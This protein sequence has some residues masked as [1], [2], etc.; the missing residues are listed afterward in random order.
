MLVPLPGLS[1]LK[2]LHLSPVPAQEITPKITPQTLQTTATQLTVIA[3]ETAFGIRPI[4]H[5]SR[6]RYAFGVRAHVTARQ[7]RGG[8]RGPVRLDSL[9]L[10]SP[11]PETVEVFGSAT[12]AA[13]PHGF[14]ASLEKTGRQQWR[15]RTFR[16]I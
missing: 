13:H 5:L 2:V 16:I 4:Q 15:M 3:L 9:H 11:D 7:H 14:T 8:L 12:V 10:R 6:K 1:H